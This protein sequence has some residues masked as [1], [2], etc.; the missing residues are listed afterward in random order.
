MNMATKGFIGFLTKK[1]MA[2][3]LTVVAITCVNFIIFRMAPGDPVRMMFRDPRVSAQQM[4]EVRK[5]FGLDK[6][7]WGQFGAYMRELGRGN[8]GISFWQRRP[9][10]E[11]ILS[12]IP[13]TILLVLTALAIAM[14]LGTLLGAAAGWRSGSRFDSFI[15]GA[16]LAAY[17][18]PT[19]A[20]GLILMLVFA[21]VLALFP[22][23]GISTP[24]SGL[25]G[26][27][28]LGDLLWH[29]TL[30]AV[31][32][33]FWYLGEYAL[34]TRSAMIDVLGQDYIVTAKVKGIR[35]KRIL[36][37]HALRNALLPVVTITGVNIAFA[38]GGVIEAETVFSWP[39]IGRLA[40]EAVM[41]RDYPLLQGIFLFFGIAV[42]ILNLTVDLVYRFVDPRIKIGTKEH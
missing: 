35:E 30:P 26:L 24:A 42:V 29:L 19:F 37:R 2:A 1:I 38:I 15:M 20:M 14:V 3:I 27:A 8:L 9:V 13:N 12:R 11:V 39:G 18:V 23:G 16:S 28:H 31:S 34:L 36:Y 10:T 32:L 40:F 25:S 33:I 21:Y 6:P 17:S 41:K 22:L 5:E 7:L 4:E